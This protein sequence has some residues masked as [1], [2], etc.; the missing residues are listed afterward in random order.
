MGERRRQVYL[1]GMTF[2]INAFPHSHTY[3]LWCFLL[4]QSLKTLR[5]DKE[6]DNKDDQDH[7][8]NTIWLNIKILVILLKWV[9]S[10]KSQEALEHDKCKM[11]SW[12]SL[13]PW[14]VFDD[15][16]FSL[17]VALFRIC[18]RSSCTKWASILFFFLN[19]KP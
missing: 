8:A 17:Y 4:L 16:K 9:M 5:N 14:Y 19:L 6:D 15:L 18:W 10:G 1:K 12:V 13:N 7:I 11:M 3:I 2:L